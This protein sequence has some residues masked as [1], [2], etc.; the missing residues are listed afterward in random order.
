MIGSG[1]Y[2]KDY[3]GWFDCHQCEEEVEAEGTTDDSQTTAYAKCPKCE[4]DMEKDIG[5]E[6]EYDLADEYWKER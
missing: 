1:I 3:S 4:Y 5:D 2:A 6:H